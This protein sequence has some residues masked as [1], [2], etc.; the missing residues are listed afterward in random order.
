[1][2]SKSQAR[3][4][5]RAQNNANPQEWPATHDQAEIATQP[6]SRP[7]DERLARGHWTAPDK[8]AGGAY[9]DLA[10]DMIGRLMVS[11]Q[12]TDEQA[13]AARGFMDIYAAY[14]V[15]IGITESKSCLAVSSGG[16]DP[17]DGNEAVYKHY[18]AI[19]DR[20]GSAKTS[21]LQTECGKAADD[22]PVNLAALRNALDCLA[23]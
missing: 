4:N 2:T 7:T 8:K 20:I 1:V 14:L 16:F 3:R 10:C 15:E 11:K 23:S 12:I 21:L 18:Y 17:S 13:Q 22:K 6:T 19:R 5:K 9:V